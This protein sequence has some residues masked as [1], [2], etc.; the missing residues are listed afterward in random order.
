MK[1]LREFATRDDLTDAQVIQGRLTTKLIFQ[2]DV[3]K[4]QQVEGF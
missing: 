3:C 2:S 1:H 4:L